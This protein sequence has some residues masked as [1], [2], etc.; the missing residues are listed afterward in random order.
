MCVCVCMSVKPKRIGGSL[1][2]DLGLYRTTM[3]IC[4][5]YGCPQQS[6]LI[7][8]QE[9]SLRSLNI[10]QSDKLMSLWSVKLHKRTSLKLKI[11]FF[12]RLQRNGLYQDSGCT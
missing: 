4:F 11:F 1:S 6:R 10:P 5:Q 9:A 7:E 12:T 3:H 8:L 2:V